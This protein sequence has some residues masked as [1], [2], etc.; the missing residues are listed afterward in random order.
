MTK[1]Q[2]NV[3]TRKE[4]AKELVRLWRDYEAYCRAINANDGQPDWEGFISWM[5]YSA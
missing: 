5:E 1:D 2:S 4:L 3:V